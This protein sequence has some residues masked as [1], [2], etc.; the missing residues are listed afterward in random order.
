MQSAIFVTLLTL[1]LAT[2]T[3]AKTAAS[4]SDTDRYNWVVQEIQKQDPEILNAMLATARA[5]SQIDVPHVSKV[6]T[7]ES[8][9][10]FLTCVIGKASARKKLEAG[11]CINRQGKVFTLVGFGAGLTAA[12]AGSVL[13][14][15]VKSSD[16]KI[17]GEYATADVGLFPSLLRLKAGFGGDFIFGTSAHGDDKTILLVG[18]SYGFGFDVSNLFFKLD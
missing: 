13:V 7:A 5:A 15:F 6:A 10:T 16:G 12:L 17:R 8:K 3:H 2:T 18:P 4:D 9:I 1:A 11:A 14:G